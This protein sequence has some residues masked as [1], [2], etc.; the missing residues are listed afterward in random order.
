MIDVEAL[1]GFFE[2]DSS[3]GGQN[4]DLTH[5]TAEHLAVHAGFFDEGLRADDH[6][7]DGSAESFGKAEHHGIEMARD[8]RDL[9]AQRHRGVKDACAIEMNFQSGG[10]SAAADIVDLRDGV[11]RATSHVVRIL[12]TNESGLRVVINPGPDQ[13]CN[14]RPGQDALFAA[15]HTR[16]ATRNRGH[17]GEFVEIDVAALF[18]DDF[19]AVMGP[20]FYCDEVAHATAGN[21]ERRFLAKDFRGAALQCIHSGVFEIHI[22]ADF[23]F[24]HGAAH[25]GRGAR[26]GIAAQIDDAGGVA[27]RLQFS[28]RIACRL[29]RHCLG[30][31]AEDGSLQLTHEF[32]KHFVRNAEALRRQAHHA[33]GALDQA[34]RLERGEAIADGDAI[35]ILQA[36]KIDAGKLAKSEK[37]FF[38]ERLRRGDF[39]QLLD[40]RP[41]G[42]N[43]LH[44]GSGIVGVGPAV[45]AGKGMRTGAKSEVRFAT[46]IFAVVPRSKSRLREI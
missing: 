27:R 41:T 8:F 46:P 25:R 39:F 9:H 21:K 11:E 29:C 34:G 7:A 35:G 44:I 10:M 31:L 45:R 17:G 23:G 19:V 38:F 4:A 30:S 37:E 15:R 3:G 20:D 28:F 6:G 33:S 13:R 12:E 22:V 26:D 36:V 18:A 43:A 24:S 42:C 32:D 14:L 5:A 40:R 2:R 16:H 1:G